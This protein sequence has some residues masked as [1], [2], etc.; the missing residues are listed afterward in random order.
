MDKEEIR[1]WLKA[2]GEAANILGL[3]GYS[4][5]QVNVDF[6]LKPQDL[7]DQDSIGKQQLQLGK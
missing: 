7:G 1:A 3:G 6:I 4:W 5:A 2:G